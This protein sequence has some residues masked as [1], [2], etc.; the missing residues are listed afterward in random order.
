MAF[1]AVP[2]LAQNAQ[3]VETVV[4]TGSRLP[5][6]YQAPT[7]VTVLDASQIKASGLVNIED[8]LNETP[9]FRG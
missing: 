8:T 5:S 4:V 2:A 3:N 6:T 1:C 7:P 9:Q